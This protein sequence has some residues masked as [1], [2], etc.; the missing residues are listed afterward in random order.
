MNSSLCFM[1][2][3]IW[4]KAGREGEGE[5]ERGGREG[6]RVKGGR[7]VNKMFKCLVSIHYTATLH[8]YM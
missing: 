1:K 5:E 4:E 7:R 8:R 6:E 3:N 2:S